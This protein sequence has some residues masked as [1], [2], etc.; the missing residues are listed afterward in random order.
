MTLAAA[1][2][3]DIE[4]QI[5]ALGPQFADPVWRL[6]NLYW[7]IDK[8]SNAV[9][10]RL[11]PQQRRFLER[12]WF[13]NIILK[14]R[15]Q[16]FSTLLQIMELDQALFNANYNGVVTADTLP[17]AGKLFAKIEFAYERLPEA[18]RMALPI[19]SKTTLETIRFAH[20]STISVGVSARGGTVNLL[21]VS[22]HGKIAAKSPERSREII[23]GA[24]EAVPVDGAIVVE[25]TAEGAAGDFYDLVVPAL[26]RMREG[27]KETQLDF[28]LHFFAWFESDE[29]R[30]SPADAAQTVISKD[31]HRYFDKL[32]A[33]LGIKL[34]VCQ[35]AWYVKKRETLGR[36]MKREYP[37][38]PEEAFEQ[39]IEGAVYGEQMT[40]LREHGRIGVVP[41]D[42]NYPVNTFWDLG[43]R[44]KTAI[45]LHQ[46][47]NTQHRWI[48]YTEDSNK[49]LAY[50]WHDDL[51]VWRAKHGARW[52]KHHLPHDAATEIL[53]ASI[54]THQRTLDKLG[55]RDSII[56]PRVAE[57]SIG[58]NQTRAALR[59]NHWFDRVECAQGIKC[60]DGYQYVWND[61]AGVWS[62]EP[63]HNW[64]SHGADA[65]RQY[66][67]GFNE[68]GQVDRE[69]RNARRSRRNWKTA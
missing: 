8:N 55:M 30:L 1:K 46:L 69:E 52:G 38:T 66:A 28:R 50:Y 42:P 24:F 33:D 21:H 48:R 41:V 37:S 32:Q 40:W 26:A 49:D 12:F 23:T 57:L 54:T 14:A 10:F 62:S 61:K 45:W 7:I 58:I 53:G 16:G 11:N 9:R 13:R 39:A 17:N 29:Y 3:A 20:G 35:R 43:K 6:D 67:Q 5:A 60:L 25:S 4:A 27:G 68:P 19:K 65:W 64:A 31:D 36:D 22:E 18:V 59:G 44:D 47:V 2:P 15:Q 63:R 34:D 56:V 51:E